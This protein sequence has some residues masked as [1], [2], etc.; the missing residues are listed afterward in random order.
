ML[1]ET[2]PPDNALPNNAPPDDEA[3]RLLFDRAVNALRTVYDPEI[4]VN[5]WD[6]GLIYKVRVNIDG[7]VEIDMTLTSPGCPIAQEMPGMVQEAVLKAEGVLSCKVE[8]VWD[9]PWRTDFMSETAR[10]ELDMFY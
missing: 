5:I 4:P 10:L 1:D 7:T 8:I 6:L 9:P 2:N 3:E